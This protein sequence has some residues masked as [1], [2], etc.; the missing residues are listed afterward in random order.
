MKVLLTEAEKMSFFHTAL[1]NGLECLGDYGLEIEFSNVDYMKASKHLKENDE[2]CCYEDVLVQLLKFGNS[3]V[4]KDTEDDD[5]TKEITLATIYE[6]MENVP[7]QNLLNVLEENDDAE[8]ADIILQTVI[9][10]EIIFG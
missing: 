7:L 5:L 6:R 8:D 2:S 10:N 9:Y 4:V 3:I 1:C